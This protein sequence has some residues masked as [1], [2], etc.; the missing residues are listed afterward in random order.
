MTTP[1]PNFIDGHWRKSAIA[2]PNTNPSNLSDVIGEYAMAS[3]ADLNDSVAAARR[4]FASWSTSCIQARSDALDRI[5]TEILARRE[6]LGRLLSREEGKTLPEGMGEVTRAGQIFKVFRRR[7]PA[8]G[9]RVYSLSTPRRGRGDHSRIRGRYRHDHPLE[10]PNR[11]SGVEDC[12]GTRL[13]K[14]RGIQA[15]RSGAWQ[16]LGAVRD[17]QPQRYPGGRF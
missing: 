16:R 17:H 13:G 3:E 4:A 2:K 1:H 6:E 5:G 10:L 15:R 11:Y 7:M 14:L 8:N 9:G 12:T